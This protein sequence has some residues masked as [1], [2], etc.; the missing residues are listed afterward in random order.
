VK[1]LWKRSIVLPSWR[2][3]VRVALSPE[4]VALAR[5]SRRWQP[6]VIAKH[7]VEYAGGAPSDWRYCVEP[8]QQAL[9]APAFGGADACVVISSHFVR[10]ALVPWSEHLVADDEKRAWVAHQFTELYGEPAAP[11]EYR[12]SE[13]KPN[14]PCV[15]SAV[16]SEFMA[17]IRAA[18]EASSLKLRS[19]QPYLMAAFNRCKRHV[20]GNRSWLVLPENGRACIATL[21]RGEWRTL[22]CKN[23]EPDWR[24]GLSLLLERQLLLAED[25][26]PA[27][28][29][30]YG[31]NLTSAD[32]PPASDIAIKV[33]APKALLGF[34]PYS[35]AEYGM[36]LTGVA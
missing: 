8:L 23:L 36:A 35:D 10:Y 14:A 15:A 3:E 4:R 19:V 28:L 9:Q 30:A 21:A 6:K 22:T 29:I 25:E 32:L 16:E 24:A 11:L 12:W 1:Q 20:N 2:D 5:L 17:H 33:V 26:A 7:V 27:A 18:F 31:A 13:D 34:S